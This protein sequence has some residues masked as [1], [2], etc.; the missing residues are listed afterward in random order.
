[1][2]L[3]CALTIFNIWGVTCFVEMNNAFILSQW[4][5]EGFLLLLL[6]HQANI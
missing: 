6:H 4:R 2:V 3:K 1:M 5:P